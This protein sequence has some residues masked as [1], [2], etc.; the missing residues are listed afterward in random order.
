M[1][2]P[3]LLLQLIVKKLNRNRDQYHAKQRLH[4]WVDAQPVPDA[5]VLVASAVSHAIV[6]CGCFGL[7]PSIVG[8]GYFIR[9]EEFLVVL[10]LK[11]K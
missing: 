11:V 9:R 3:P 2:V 10:M 6:R 5:V 1:V 4:G 7:L 8:R